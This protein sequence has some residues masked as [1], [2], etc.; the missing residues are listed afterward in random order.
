MLVLLEWAGL[1]S[2]VYRVER[3]AQCL[4][5]GKVGAE[6][7]CLESVCEGVLN[8]RAG[9]CVCVGESQVRQF[10]DQDV[11]DDGIEC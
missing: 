7:N 11:R 4:I 9:V 5:G 10:A 3:H 6:F 8:P 2:V 1:Q